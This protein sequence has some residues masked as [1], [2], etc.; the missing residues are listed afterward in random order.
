[1]ILAEQS[2]LISDIHFFESYP[3]NRR[4]SLFIGQNIYLYNKHTTMTDGKYYASSSA[5]ATAP[6]GSIIFTIDEADI[7]SR[8]RFVFLN[9][10]WLKVLSFKKITNRITA[11]T[12]T[13]LDDSV[14]IKVTKGDAV[15]FDV[16]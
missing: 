5:E 4:G 7:S 16:D 6:G 11:I 12:A 2:N 10:E 9:N 3:A 1:M 14:T 15:I 13:P 8:N